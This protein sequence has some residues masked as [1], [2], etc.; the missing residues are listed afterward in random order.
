M[1]EKGETYAIQKT[2][3]I[4]HIPWQVKFLP[5]ICFSWM[6]CDKEKQQLTGSCQRDC[7]LVS[8][9]LMLDPLT[10]LLMLDPFKNL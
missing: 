8:T 4:M 10:V 7:H 1:Q 3:R 6:S 9:I 5:H 2:L